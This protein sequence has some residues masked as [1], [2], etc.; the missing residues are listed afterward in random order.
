MANGLVDSQIFV[1]L[2]EIWVFFEPNF[3]YKRA[4]KGQTTPHANNH[5][6]TTVWSWDTTEPILEPRSGGYNIWH[7]SRSEA[8]FM[9]TDSDFG[10]ALK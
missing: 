1:H 7:G 4:E 9:A 3:L 8:H 2:C 6:S 5:I 10:D